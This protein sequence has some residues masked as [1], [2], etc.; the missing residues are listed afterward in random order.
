MKKFFFTINVCSNLGTGKTR[1]LVALIQ[2]IVRTTSDNVLVC[3]MTN[4]ACDLI[5]ENLL[6]IL[7]AGELFRLYSTSTKSFSVSPRILKVANFRKE[8]SKYVMPKMYPSL[9]YLYKFRVVVC[10]SSMAGL[11]TRARCSPN[12]SVNHFSYVIIDECGC[13][14]EPISLIP[15]AGKTYRVP[16]FF[17]R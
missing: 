2:Q 6:D 17:M 3:A 16:S 12:W 11:F 7:Y 4:A 14:P 15:I 13:A 1:T 10:T 9:Y 5:T 8:K